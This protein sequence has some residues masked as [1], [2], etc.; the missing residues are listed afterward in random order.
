[1]PALPGNANDFIEQQLDDR[2]SLL[3]GTFN[4]HVITFCGGIW[5]GVDDLLRSAVEKKC[6]QEPR[7]RKL[8]VI[9]T[10]GGG[11]IEIVQRIVGTLRR[12]YRL[13]DFVIPNY[14]YSAGTVLAMSGDSIY[15]DYYSRLGPIDPQVQSQG[16]SQVPALGY[17]ERYNDLIAKAQAG[18][19]VTAEVQ[20]LIDGFD[21]AELYQYE[22]AR[23][24]SIALL[25]EWLVKYKFK[26][27]KVTRTRKLRVT[28]Q[29]K[30]DRA[31][32]IAKE[33]NNTKRWHVHGHGIAMEVLERDLNLMIDDFGKDQ[34]LSAK[35]RG[36]H[37]LLSDYMVKRQTQGV[38]H[39]KGEYRPFM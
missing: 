22:H 9:L 23:E 1:M 7:R 35:V 31:A 6:Q 11:Y 33:L 28:R 24:L 12:Y 30:V 5:F 15:M 2:I 16:G 34:D 8:V 29:M 25:K 36:Y 14:A 39:F 37:D 4:A 32:Q 38:I 20:L 13:V 27:W 19:I 26:N 18:T 3:E 17:L 21:Q 10:T